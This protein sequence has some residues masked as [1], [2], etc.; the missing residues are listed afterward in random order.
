MSHTSLGLAAAHLNAAVGAILSEDDLARALRSGSLEAVDGAPV[1]AALISS[2]FVE[3]AP[4]LVSRCASEAGADFAH[5]NMLYEETLRR[6]AVRVQAWEKAVE[7][8]I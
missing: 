4:S 1:K 6:G 8:L 7:H 2:L 3:L 5:A